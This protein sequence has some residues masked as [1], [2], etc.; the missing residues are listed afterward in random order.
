MDMAFTLGREA[1]FSQLACIFSL[2]SSR[3]RGSFNHTPT[4]P[5]E[6]PHLTVCSDHLSLAFPL[7]VFDS[8]AITL[9][10][11]RDCIASGE[12]FLL[13]GKRLHKSTKGGA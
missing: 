11:M 8:L 1:S 13:L 10:T 5:R 6:D 2:M 3:K 4:V 12:L 7:L 9:I